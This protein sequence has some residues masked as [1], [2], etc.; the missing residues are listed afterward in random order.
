M[1]ALAD[2]KRLV[3]EQLL[4]AEDYFLLIIDPRQEGVVL[5]P[6][7]ID[8]GQPVALNVGH[9]MPVPIPDLVVDERGVAGTLSFDRSP[10]HCTLPWA[11]VV[12]ISA[13]NEHLV[14]VVPPPETPV[15]TPKRERPKLRVV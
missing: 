7:L 4:A 15:T 10:F 3:L 8:A 9:R 2:T 11:A 13:G 1:G 12:Q 5:P 6:D 14:W